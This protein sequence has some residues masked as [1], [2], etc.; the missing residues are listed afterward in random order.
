MSAR[1][2]IVSA[3]LDPERTCELWGSWSARAAG[4]VETC[5]IIGEVGMVAAF[6]KGVRQAVARGAD[7][8]ACFHD[9]LRIDEQGWDRKVVEWFAAHPRCGLAGFGGAR[10]LGARD[11]YTVPYSAQQLARGGFMSNLADA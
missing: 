8:I 2:C 7:I 5:H 4:A 1:L 6:A 11:I 9:D 10:S 3:S